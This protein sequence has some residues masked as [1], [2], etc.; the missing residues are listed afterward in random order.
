MH[1][2]PLGPSPNPEVEK[3]PPDNFKS[4]TRTALKATHAC[5]SG[6]PHLPIQVLLQANGTVGGGAAAQGIQRTTAALT[7]PFQLGCELPGLHLFQS[8]HSQAVQ[9]I[10]PLREKKT[11]HWLWVGTAMLRKPCSA[12]WGD[13]DNSDQACHLHPSRSPGSPGTTENHSTSLQVLMLAV[14]SAPPPIQ[15]ER[16]G[17]VSH[18]SAW[19]HCKGA[20]WGQ[21]RPRRLLLTWLRRCFSLILTRRTRQTRET[22]T[23][24]ARKIPMSKYSVG[25]F[26]AEGDRQ[27]VT[28]LLSF[29]AASQEK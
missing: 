16:W 25:C 17:Y 4:K 18:S 19:D 3:G 22:T 26:G 14:T 7:V 24:K 8:L 2:T 21:D 20:F 9:G 15:R 13:H 10:L 27:T 29:I 1:L 5:P 6:P 11:Y 23:K 12:G 28:S